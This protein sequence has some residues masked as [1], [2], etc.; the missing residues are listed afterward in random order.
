[1][2]NEKNLKIIPVILF[3]FCI[4]EIFELA[5]I[6]GVMKMSEDLE[7]KIE[8]NLKVLEHI[9]IL[10][11]EHLEGMDSKHFKDKKIKDK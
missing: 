6:V 1:M 2:W 9:T 10:L 4:L 7:V 8:N 11:D 5:L 3:L